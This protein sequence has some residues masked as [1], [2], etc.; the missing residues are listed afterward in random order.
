MCFPVRLL[1]P[2]RLPD[3]QRAGTAQVIAAQPVTKG[4]SKPPSA[5]GCA[6]E[7][8][9]TSAGGERR[10]PDCADHPLRILDRW[11]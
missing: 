4:S 11:A 1:E 2:S 3:P 5:A 6:P 10:G 8:Q 9:R 7:W